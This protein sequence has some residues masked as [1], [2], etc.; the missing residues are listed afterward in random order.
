VQ[1]GSD[2]LARPGHHHTAHQHECA[3]PEWHDATLSP[4]ERRLLLANANRSE[5]QFTLNQDNTKFTAQFDDL[6]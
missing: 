2:H 4:A 1:T 5:F 3:K 6:F